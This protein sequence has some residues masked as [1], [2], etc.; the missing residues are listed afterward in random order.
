MAFAGNL[1]PTDIATITDLTL[2]PLGANRGTARGRALLRQSL[3]DFGI[4]RSI[5]IDASGRVIAGN[6]VLEVARDLAMPIQVVATEGER[7]VVVQRRDLD[8]ETDPKA[9]RL[10]IADN[11]VAE[12][13]LEWDP[14]ILA[15][16]QTDGVPLDELFTRDELERLVG[17]GLN[18]GETDENEVLDPPVTSTIRRGELFGL[19]SHRLLCGDATNPADVGRV[20]GDDRPALMTTDPPYGVSYDASWRHAYDPTARTAV[21][22]VSNDDCV[23]WRAAWQLFPGTVM[24]IWHAGLHAG[25]VSASI[26]ATGFELRAQIVWVKPH[27]VLSRGA[28]HWRHEPCFYAVRTGADA[29]WVGDRTQTTVWEVP[30][31]NP[32][33]GD[34]AG[35]NAATGHSTQKP[36]RL[37]E[38][39]ILNHTCRGAST[40][41]PFLG[42]G[43]ALIAAEKT[44]RRC[45]AMEL[46]PRYV[47]V[48][49]ERWERFTGLTAVKIGDAEPDVD[50]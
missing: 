49:I 1:P 18:A 8:L 33:G 36:V 35:E 2:D 7:L 38:I 45:L 34:R 28:Y 14:E 12:L 16:L 43:T 5:V 11:R 50:A 44:G 6:K 32:F 39:P 24:Y 23:D 30:N 47:Q 46:E 4:G 42:S 15:R 22:R 3:E 41:D 31:L 37:F 19:G 25:D 40:F 13:N 26:T 29:G 10:A 17:H 9:R 21:G 20:L 27:L 48:A